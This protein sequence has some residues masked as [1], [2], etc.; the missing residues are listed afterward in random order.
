MFVYINKSSVVV[1]SRRYSCFGVTD[2]AFVLLVFVG[3]LVVPRLVVGVFQSP[4]RFAIIKELLP[5]AKVFEA[6]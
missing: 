6:S 2:A 1:F 3:E 4:F 5:P